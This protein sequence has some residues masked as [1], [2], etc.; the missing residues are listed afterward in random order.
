VDERAFEGA[1]VMVL[2]TVLER[3]FARYASL[4]SFT[5]LT[6]VSQTRGEIKRW[7]PRIGLRAIA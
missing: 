1:G 4:N 6:L 2:G 3:F 5:Q 7:K